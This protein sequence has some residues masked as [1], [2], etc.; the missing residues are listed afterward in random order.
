LVACFRAIRGPDTKIVES[1]ER[2]CYKPQFVAEIV[3]LHHSA[4]KGRENLPRF[5]SFSPLPHPNSHFF[6]LSTL[7]AILTAKSPMLLPVKFYCRVPIPLVSR[8]TVI[9]TIQLRPS[10]PARRVSLPSRPTRIPTQALPSLS[11][12]SLTTPFL[13]L[14]YPP[15]NRIGVFQPR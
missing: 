9:Y 1:N 8:C 15:L 6:I 10:L 7:L 4:S 14:K 5:S 12:K 13:P 3:K 2:L 11:S